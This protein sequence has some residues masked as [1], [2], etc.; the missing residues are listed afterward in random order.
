MGIASDASLGAS[1]GVIASTTECGAENVTAAAVA[2]TAAESTTSELVAAQRAFFASGKT[3]DIEYRRKALLRLQS[4][5]RTHERELSEALRCDLGKSPFESYMC[6]VGLSLSELAY[7]LKHVRQWAAPHHIFSGMA[8]FPSVTYTTAEPYGVTLVMSPWNYPF[9]LSI[10]PLIAA[11]AAG[12][13]CVVKPSAYSPATSAALA[14]LVHTVFEPGHV[15]VVLGGREE[16][17]QL[18][19]QRWDFIFFTGSPSVGRLVME[20]ASKHVTPVCLELG[21]KSPCVIC[22]DADLPLASTRIAFGKWLNVG[23][24]CIAP[25]YVLVDA[26]I[27]HEFCEMLQAAAK[28]MY[29]EDAFQNPDYG[30]LVN[31]KHFN[32]VLSLIEKEKLVFGGRA[33]EETLQIEPTVLYCDGS[34]AVMQEEIFGPLL[35]VIPYN[36]IQEAEAFIKAREKPLALYLFTENKAVQNRFVKHVSFGGGCINDTIVHIASNELP[37]GGVGN[38][39]MGSYHGK[40]SFLTFSHTKSILKKYSLDIPLRYQPYSAQKEKIVRLFL[41]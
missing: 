29:G 41:H 27:A 13:C 34:E 38:S 23:Q 26:K 25:D 35:P 5:I 39:G 22:D 31:K 6:E 7:H 28:I 2:N 8:N 11:V 32:R 18:L 17:T 37:F 3:I 21:G 40:S 10:E 14:K 19:E 15:D 30:H 33:K 16:N 4:Y 9:L 24:T 1:A 12:N 20:K 36:T